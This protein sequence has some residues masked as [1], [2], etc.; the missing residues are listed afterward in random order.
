MWYM[1]IHQCYQFV[2]FTFSHCIIVHATVKIRSTLIP[3]GFIFLLF[4]AIPPPTTPSTETTS[5]TPGGPN[6]GAR[7][8]SG[9]SDAAMWGIIGACIAVVLIVVV[10]LLVWCCVKKRK[11]GAGKGKY[12]TF[13]ERRLQKKTLIPE[14]NGEKIDT[15]KSNVFQSV[16]TQIA[17]RDFFPGGEGRRWRLFKIVMHAG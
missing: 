7:G 17:L 3:S 14:E 9:L 6:V 1:V 16:K 11:G 12:P 5:G 10:I 15:S 4:L 8:S 13:V 2:T